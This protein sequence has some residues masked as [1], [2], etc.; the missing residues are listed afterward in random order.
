LLLPLCVFDMFIF[1]ARFCVSF[2]HESNVYITNTNTGTR[3]Q[4]HYYDFIMCVGVTSVCVCVISV[5]SYQ[6]TF[7]ENFM[8]YTQKLPKPSNLNH[9][10]PRPCHPIPFCVSSF[11]YAI[12]STSFYCK[13]T[14]T[15]T[16]TPTQIQT[17]T[18]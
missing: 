8:A 13:H 14:R 3:T 10:L 7:G 12:C 18:D 17:Q 11:Y 2:L 16:P 9:L 4:T 6:T 1:V 5:C 15:D